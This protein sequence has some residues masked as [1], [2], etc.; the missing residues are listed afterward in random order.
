[1]SLRFFHASFASSSD[2][3]QPLPDLLLFRPGDLPDDLAVAQED[4]GG[5]QLHP[6]RPSKR[7]PLAVLHLDVLH[8]RVLAEQ[9]RQLRL[10]R[11][12]VSSPVGAELQDERARHLIDFCTG[13]W[14]PVGIYRVE[15][16]RL[17]SLA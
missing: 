8:L 12:A 10:E 4:Q 2:G 1:M 11:V 15:C 14:L 6:E 9:R 16:H 7:S 13:R 17:A 5:P 3:I